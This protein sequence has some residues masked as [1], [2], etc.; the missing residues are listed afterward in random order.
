MKMRRTATLLL[1]LSLICVAFFSCGGKSEAPKPRA[2]VVKKVK[3]KA[4]AG[5]EKKAGETGKEEFPGYTATNL[6]DPFVPFIREKIVPVARKTRA[7]TPLEKFDLGELKLVGILMKGNERVA[8]VEDNQGKGYMVKKGTRI[9]KN[10]GVVTRI[11][12]E[13]VVVVEEFYDFSGRR[14]KKEKTL[15]LPKSGGE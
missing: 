14:V 3:K 12:D 15:A 2:K 5:E 9:G 4:P 11:T 13:T 7:L 10:G 8:L 6:R 1:V